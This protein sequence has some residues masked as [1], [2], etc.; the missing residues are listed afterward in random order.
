[1]VLLAY[2][3]AD[4]IPRITSHHVGSVVYRASCIGQDCD[5]SVTA[6]TSA[7]RPISIPEASTLTFGCGSDVARF[8]LYETSLSTGVRLTRPCPDAKL[9]AAWPT[10]MG[11]PPG[12]FELAAVKVENA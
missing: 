10:V 1:M 9:V 6:M 11:L 3:R 4:G 2:A 12:S 8:T 7:G 5:V